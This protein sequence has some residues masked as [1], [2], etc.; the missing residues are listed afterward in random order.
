MKVSA[1]PS[2]MRC[3]LLALLSTLISAHRLPAPIVEPEEKPTPAAE[4]SEA[5]KR[6]HSTKPKTTSSDAEQAK[7]QPSPSAAPAR[8]LPSGPAKFAGTWSGRI[9][10]GIIGNIQ[11]KLVINANATTVTDSSSS[12]FGGA[13]HAAKLNGDTLQWHA[14]WLKEVTWTLTPNTDGQTAAITAKSPLGV[15]GSATFSRSQEA[16]SK[17]TAAATPPPIPTPASASSSPQQTEFPTAKP[18]PGKPGFVFD[19]FDP[20]SKVYLDVR[21]MAPGTKVKILTSG[22]FFIVP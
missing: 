8:S 6:K 21:G 20:S 18:V 12:N 22:K 9:N 11:I 14:G 10:Q 4:E 19:L 17:I 7:A 13:T 16:E 5:P 2:R 3:F 15:N 1:W